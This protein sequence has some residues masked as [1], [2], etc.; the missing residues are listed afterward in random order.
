M[1]TE[2]ILAT[3][4]VV[5]VAAVALALLLK[6]VNAHRGHLGFFADRHLRRHGVAEDMRWEAR[7][8][9]AKGGSIRKLRTPKTFLDIFQ[10]HQAKPNVIT[11]PFGLGDA[12]AFL[13]PHYATGGR[14]LLQTLFQAA[15]YRNYISKNNWPQDEFLHQAAA[16][17][18]KIL[19]TT[20]TSVATI[21]LYIKK[22][23]TETALDALENGLPIEYATTL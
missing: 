22:L 9:Q 23:K 5:L 3:A 12:L 16:R 8:Y 13:E 11:A 6:K 1:S 7:D 19:S 15:D 14:D 17:I 21:D 18:E 2:A 4:I 10:Y 20:D